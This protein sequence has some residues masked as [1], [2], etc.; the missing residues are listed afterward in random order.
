MK[1]R[2]FILFIFFTCL[3]GNL[4]ENPN[5]KVN[6]AEVTTTVESMT[7]ENDNAILHFSDGTQS[8]H[9]MSIVEILFP[10]ISTLTENSSYILSQIVH[11]QLV[12]E[13]CAPNQLVSI[14]DRAGRLMCQRRSEDG[15]LTIS[16][17]HLNAG[18]YCLN[19]GNET[20]KF[21]KQ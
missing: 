17:T 10:Q 1:S 11:D 13:N 5:F 2:L 16:L 6:G 7:F 3:Y 20:V 15:R 9:D 21:I 4:W 18:V 14:F 19:I 12:I 8:T